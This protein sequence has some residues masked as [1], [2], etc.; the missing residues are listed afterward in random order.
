MRL[1]RPRGRSGS[2]GEPR[3]PRSVPALTVALGG[4]GIGGGLEAGRLP[5][6]PHR[7]GAALV[8][9]LLATLIVAGLLQLK[10][11]Y[12]NHV[13][14][15]DL[16]EA[17]VAPLIIAVPGLG[18]VVVVAA[19]KAISQ[20]ILKVRPAKAWFNTAQWSAAAAAGTLVFGLLRSPGPLGAVDLWPLVLA[21]LSVT[22]VNQVAF[23]SVLC[24][25]DQRPAREVLAE[26]RP[27]VISGWVVGGA[28]VLSFGILFTAAFNWAPA[29]VLLFAVPLVLLHW[30]SRSYGIG[31]AHRMR[32]RGLQQATHTLAVPVD[33]REALPLF[34]EEVRK[35]FGAEIVELVTSHD[36][37]LQS[38][39]RAVAAEVTPTSLPEL[40]SPERRR[41][42]EA[43]MEGRQTV[44][45]RAASPGADN[46]QLLASLGLRDCLA[47]PVYAGEAVTGLLCAYNRT[48]FEGSRE[49]ETGVMTA[50]A[51]EVG[52]ALEKGRLIDT[53]SAEREK[54]QDS[55]ARFRV[56]VQDSSDMV[57]VVDAAGLLTYCSPAFS[58]LVGDDATLPGRYMFTPVH[59]D[60][61]AIVEATLKRC[62]ATSGTRF[63]VECRLRAA[64]GAWRHVETLLQNLLDHPAI[65]GIVLNSRN[66]TER[67][68]AD[69]LVSGQARVL[70][71]IARGAPLDDTLLAVIEVV[72]AQL[73][74]VVAAV[75]L[76]DT[77]TRIR[78]RAARSLEQPILDELD[79]VLAEERPAKGAA[80]WPLAKPL[81]L[82]DIGTKTGWPPFSEARL[83]GFRAVWLI[84][85]PAPDRHTLTGILALYR[86]ESG[87]PD[88]KAW[89]LVDVATR[90]ANMAIERIQVQAD[91]AHQAT[92]DLLT[93]LPNRLLFNDRLAAATARGVRRD[94]AVA[95]MFIDLDRFKA[96]NDGMGHEAGDKLLIECAR[97]LER[98]VRPWDTVARFGGDEF[99]IL[100]DDIEDESRCD[101]RR[102]SNT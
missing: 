28:V 55:E 36:G 78:T 60:D 3:I 2:T 37:L 85:I 51:G 77:T 14:A 96:V 80:R 61:R 73:P 98:S 70:E 26:L 43:L 16:F 39:T 89:R 90:L 31:L 4:L 87:A 46:A 53:L 11:R 23:V 12:R 66:I 54:L 13:E 21:V 94:A 81:I 88:P 57:C 72:E 7:T 74:E 102:Q 52:S 24:L 69:A 17:V 1:A 71:S 59:P 5:G 19:A 63:T 100:C 42:M 40:D 8:V 95:V 58:R 56:L 68:R 15:L 99:T 49:G 45:V 86:R 9:A 34:L 101:R 32:L 84:P 33:P 92:H 18:T 10:F 65:E 93:G 64:D 79:A 41:M 47:A 67:K 22:A 25:V 35:C 30:A 62:A 29:T 38:Q 44:D 6:Q 97:R 83:G 50:L 91:L 27:V 20:L 75:F 48:G 82:S 76:T